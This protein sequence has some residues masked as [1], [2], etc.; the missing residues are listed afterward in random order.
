VLR[1][2]RGLRRLRGT[3]WDPF[4][5]AAVRREERRLI[6][7]YRELIGAALDRLDA[8]T[9]PAV[10]ELAALP[11]AIRGYE[12]IK[13]ESVRRVRSRAAELS[14]RLTAPRDALTPRG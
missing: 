9:L 10:V 7:W 14:A 11:E 13:L 5:F 1:G 2:L 4:G 8:D 3:G 12:A 6:P